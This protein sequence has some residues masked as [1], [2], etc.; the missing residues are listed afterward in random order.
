MKTLQKLLFILILL[1]ASRL[2]IMAQPLSSASVAVTFQVDMAVQILEKK[3]TPG[4]D[5]LSVRG[6][7]ND[8][9]EGVNLLTDA[10]GDSIYTAAVN[11]PDALAGSTISFEYFYLHGVRGVGESI[12]DRQFAVPVTGGIVPLSFF[13]LD[14]VVTGRYRTFIIF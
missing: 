9:T 13:D 7:F 6:D 8:F 11:L 5:Q 12:A 3:F 4:A 1:L 14:S 2:A 10:D